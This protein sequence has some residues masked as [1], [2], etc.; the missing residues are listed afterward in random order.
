MLRNI[1]LVKF[2]VFD[3]FL[4]QIVCE[5]E[6]AFA[7][8]CSVGRVFPLYQR[9]TGPDKTIDIFVDYKFVG[10]KSEPLS[11]NEVQCFTA[12]VESIR[13]AAKIVDTPCNEMHTDIFLDVSRHENC[14]FIY[15]LYI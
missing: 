9:K 6:H 5:K 4:F 13:L 1:L 14:F 10:D 3:F 12:A 15:I 11:T 8:G 2:E 7:L